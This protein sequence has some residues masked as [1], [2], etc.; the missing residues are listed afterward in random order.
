MSNCS[1]RDA[2]A[3][4]IISAFLISGCASE[5]NTV[6]ENQRI[7]VLPESREYAESYETMIEEDIELAGAA[8]RQKR[9]VHALG[10]LNKSQP[11]PIS[12]EEIE[13]RLNKI[14]HN[15]SKGETAP[16]SAKSKNT[17]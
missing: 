17:E 7:T 10:E 13:V 4:V 11:D 15:L 5:P 3:S 2:L 8:V 9:T 1:P 14:T 16:D 12:A 6:I